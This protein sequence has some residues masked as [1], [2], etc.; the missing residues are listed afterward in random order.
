MKSALLLVLAAFACLASD[1]IRIERDGAGWNVAVSGSL[2]ASSAVNVAAAGDLTVRGTGAKEIRYTMT[3]KLRVPDEATARLFAQTLRVRGTGGWL[4]FDLPAAVRLEIPRGSQYVALSSM[5]GAID[6]ADLE[7]SLRAEASA[8]KITVDRIAGDVEIHSSGGATSI[9]TV[10]GQVRCFSG[11]GSIRAVLIRGPSL[12][13]SEGGDIWLGRALGAVRAVTAAGAIRI[14]QAGAQVHADTFGGPI[15]V[16][17]ATSVECRSASG[18]I[19]LNNVS[20]ALR[21]MTRSGSIVAEILR[22]HPLADSLLSTG[23]GDIT[24]LVPSD[25]GVTVEA[26]VAGSRDTRSIVSGFP[27][28]RI[29]AAASSVVAQGK[30]NGGGPLLRLACRGGRIEIRRQ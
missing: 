6:A 20:G 25:T 2:P 29:S 21:A 10:G 19:H 13:E 24:V 26:E 1:N 27:G 7:G 5:T 11:G 3:Q 12:F 18:A 28:L 9:G 8:G 15:V 14:D 30:I 23:D 16:G 22:G 4:V 17:A